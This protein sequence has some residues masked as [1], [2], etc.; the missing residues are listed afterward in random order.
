MM[1]SPADGG[2]IGTWKRTKVFFFF[3]YSFHSFQA[4]DKDKDMGKKCLSLSYMRPLLPWI[5]HIDIFTHFSFPTVKSSPI[6]MVFFKLGGI[7]GSW[8][9]EVQ[10]SDASYPGCGAYFWGRPQITMVVL[11]GMLQE[12]SISI[13]HVGYV[14]WGL[15]HYER[16]GLFDK[17]VELKK[18]KRM[19]GGAH[20]LHQPTTGLTCGTWRARN[21]SKVAHKLS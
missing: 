16:W 6:W 17:S 14:S 9:S 7:V 3:S 1:T 12:L 2:P 4:K 21:Q 19:E 8:Y 10:L 5:H 18:G 13:V 11:V 15:G 20:W